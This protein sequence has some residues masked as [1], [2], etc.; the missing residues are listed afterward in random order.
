MK[1]LKPGDRVAWKRLPDFDYSVSSAGEIRSERTGKVLKGGISG[2]YRTASLIRRNSAG[3]RE[4]IQVRHHHA[5]MA[6]FVSVRPPG[7]VIN[8]KNGIKT[9]NR[10][11]NLEYCTAADNRAHAVAMRLYK[12]GSRCP[13]S[14]LSQEE[15]AL[16]FRVR[17]VGMPQ[18]RIARAFGVSKK[19]IQRILSGKSW[20]YVERA[21]P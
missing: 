20:K 10:L 21:K 13:W 19:A 4:Q 12:S 18:T 5:V 2:G 14:K 6:E 15:V 9:D 17:D 11:E 1:E 7:M 3:A 8:H 16:I